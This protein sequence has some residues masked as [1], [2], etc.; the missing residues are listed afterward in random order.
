M[1]FAYLTRIQSE[2]ARLELVEVGETVLTQA[3][4]IVQGPVRVRAL[5]AI[6]VASLM[7]FQARAAIRLPFFAAGGSEMNWTG[8][9]LGIGPGVWA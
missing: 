8:S 4:E 6:L 7:A 5:D 9:I 1:T 3:E 2:R